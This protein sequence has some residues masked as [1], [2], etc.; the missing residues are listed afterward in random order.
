MNLKLKAIKKTAAMFA[1]ASI[2]LFLVIQL[3]TIPP[4]ILVWGFVIGFT[5]FFVWIVYSI[6]LGQLEFEE[7]LKK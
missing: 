1:I 6:I 5:A 3:L 4:E 2:A 7:T